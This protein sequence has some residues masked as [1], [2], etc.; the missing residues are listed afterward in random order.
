MTAKAEEEAMTVK[1]EEVSRS[2]RSFP[3]ARNADQYRLRRR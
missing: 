1:V 2:I 3:P